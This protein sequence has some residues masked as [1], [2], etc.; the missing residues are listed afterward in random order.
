MSGRLDGDWRA[1]VAGALAAPV[2]VVVGL[3]VGAIE[4]G[5]LPWD[6]CQG[7]ACVYLAVVLMYSGGI[8][9]IWAVVSG[10]VVL[11]RRRWP[12]SRVRRRILQLLAGLSYGPAVWLLVTAI[13]EG[14]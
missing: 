13:G 5:L 4:G 8:L 2:L 9:A 6:D 3:I 10:I 11:A 14:R 1:A 7:L 12:E